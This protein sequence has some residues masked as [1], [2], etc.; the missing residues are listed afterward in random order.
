MVSSIASGM[1]LLER[2]REEGIPFLWGGLPFF[3]S[4]CDWTCLQLHGGGPST[5][6]SQLLLIPP[7]KTPNQRKLS[8]SPFAALSKFSPNMFRLHPTRRVLHTRWKEERETDQE[9]GGHS[10]KVVNVQ[11]TLKFSSVSS[12]QIDQA[13]HHSAQQKGPN[14]G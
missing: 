9:E 14:I 1:Q 11:S 4:A 13:P 5:P 10:P 8:A 7:V 3:F 2:M 6:S 12:S